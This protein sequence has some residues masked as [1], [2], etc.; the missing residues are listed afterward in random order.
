MEHRPDFGDAPFREIP[1]Q[2]VEHLEHLFWRCWH[3]TPETRKRCASMICGCQADPVG[4]LGHVDA[5]RADGRVETSSA[6]RVRRG[7]RG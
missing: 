5:T 7:G 1:G 2:M 3:G 6:C 4:G